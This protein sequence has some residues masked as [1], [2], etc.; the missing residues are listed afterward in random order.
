MIASLP[1]LPPKPKAVAQS[2]PPILHVSMPHS[3]QVDFVVL[4][5]TSAAFFF[6]NVGSVGRVLR[7]FR[8]IRVRVRVRGRVRV[9][10]R[11]SVR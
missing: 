6:Q 9:S 3:R 1:K 2:S 10:V 7:V 8:P 11:V 4:V 5:L